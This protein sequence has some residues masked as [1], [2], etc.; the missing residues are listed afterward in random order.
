[1]HQDGTSSYTYEVDICDSDEFPL[2]LVAF[3]KTER[4][5]FPSSPRFRIVAAIQWV[6]RNS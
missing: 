1:M 3:D 2:S 5:V 4:E 6:C